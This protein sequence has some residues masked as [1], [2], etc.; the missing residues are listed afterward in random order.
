MR[1]WPVLLALAAGCGGPGAPP[2]VG[3]VSDAPSDALQIDA[4]IDAPAAQ[5]VPDDASTARSGI[6]GERDR[7]LSTYLAHLRSR[8]G[9]TQTNGLGAELPDVCALWDAATPATQAVFLTLTHRLFGSTL[10]DGSS[11][12]THVAT[13]YRVV[14][15]EGESAS[16]P[17]SCGGAEFNRMIVSIDP[18]LHAALLAAS[19]N[20]GARGPSGL[21]DLADAVPSSFWRDSH[22]LGGPHG[23]FTI[24]DETDGGAPRGQV[25]FFEDLA[26][27]EAMA[28]LGRTDV[29][30][31][32]DP[33]ALEMDQDYDCA[34]ASSPLCEYTF[35]GA[36]CLPRATMS[37]LDI[38]RD[39]YGLVDPSWR[40][41]GC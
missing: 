18:T 24:S 3:G 6:D 30:S 21:Y 8:P 31:L 10:A 37:G 27:A 36:A 33:Y 41:A 15:G 5:D 12:L 13:L 32:V 22:D 16:D 23:P 26:G 1:A 4:A 7:L 9:V 39:G 38:Y 11:A 28:P 40:P 2:D 14:G 17:G 19:R 25:H 20:R 35:Y 34:H 29:E